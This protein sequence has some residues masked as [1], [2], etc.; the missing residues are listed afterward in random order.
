VKH[1]E[2]HSEERIAAWMR[3]LA[4][5]DRAN[6]L[7]DPDVLWMQAQISTREAAAE[8]ALSRRVVGETA[9]T[10]LAAAVVAWAVFN[11]PKLQALLVDIHSLSQT[12]N[13]WPLTIVSF[14]GALLAAGLTFAIYPLL[15]RD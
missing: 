13:P 6:A 14:V 15:T 8:R 4:D 11:W 5:Q 12:A 1:R 2:D 9:A 10:T 7:P 3:S